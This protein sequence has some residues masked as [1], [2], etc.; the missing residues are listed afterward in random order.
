MSIINCEFLKGAW[1]G[2]RLFGDITKKEVRGDRW[3]DGGKLVGF[4][5][6]ERD[7]TCEE[8]NFLRAICKLC[9]IKLNIIACV[10]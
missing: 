4:V 8:V 5:I 1:D 3:L 6:E 9:V 7:F 10:E 2:V